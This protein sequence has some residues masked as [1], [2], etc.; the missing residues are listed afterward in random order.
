MG[1]VYSLFD[2]HKLDSG[3][4]TG[5]RTPVT[6]VTVRRNSLYTIRP[7]KDATYF[8]LGSRQTYTLSQ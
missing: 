6:E 3:G 4:R 7:E 8:W 5:N 1:L 2:T